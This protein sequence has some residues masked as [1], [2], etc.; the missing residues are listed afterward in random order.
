VLRATAAGAFFT[1]FSTVSISGCTAYLVTASGSAGSH[2]T[3]RRR[4]F[5]DCSPQ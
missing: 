2:A 5:V 1:T 3:L 4:L